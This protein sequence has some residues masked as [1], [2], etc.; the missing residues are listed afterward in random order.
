MTTTV[1]IPEKSESLK[2]KAKRWWKKAPKPDPLDTLLYIIS[3]FNGFNR[4]FLQPIIDYTWSDFFTNIVTDTVIFGFLIG[5]LIYISTMLMGKDFNFNMSYM[6]F[7]LIL[8]IAFLL[9][10]FAGMLVRHHVD[11]IHISAEV[12]PYFIIYAALELLQKF[13]PKP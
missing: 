3:M 11:P 8:E 1:F 9:P 4:G 12:I 2:E 5:F 6:S 10:Y 7:L 13:K